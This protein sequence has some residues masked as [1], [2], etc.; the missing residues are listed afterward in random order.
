MI[1]GR[2]KMNFTL[3]GLSHPVLAKHLVVYSRETQPICA[4]RDR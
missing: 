1:P 2:T 3:R 4:L